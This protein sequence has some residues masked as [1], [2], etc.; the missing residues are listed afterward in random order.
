MTISVVCT[1]C[2]AK[3][4][5]PDHLA[6]RRIQCKACQH[7]LRVA[8][9]AADSDEAMLNHSPVSSGPTEQEAVAAQS[10]SASRPAETKRSRSGDRQPPDSQKTDNGSQRSKPAGDRTKRSGELEDV[11]PPARPLPVWKRILLHASRNVW[12][13]A[14]LFYLIIWVPVICLFPFQTLMVEGMFGMMLFV[15]IVIGLIM[16]MI[17]VTMRNP[18]EVITM[19]TIGT[20]AAMIVP[21]E[22]ASATGKLAGKAA[23]RTGQRPFGE[24]DTGVG[25]TIAVYCSFGLGALIIAF[26]LRMLVAFLIGKVLR[27]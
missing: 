23:G 4:K 18:F 19:M 11:E 22:Y 15:G 3:L 25:G 27:G 2:G 8:E 6:G 16:A 5:V 20:I 21:A 24:T 10:G 9:Q 26:G 17:G 1:A 14:L 13:A 12:S 7:V